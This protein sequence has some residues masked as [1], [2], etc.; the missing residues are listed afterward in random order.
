MLEAGRGFHDMQ[1]HETEIQRQCKFK[2]IRK[3]QFPR[4]RKVGRQEKCSILA[5]GR[6]HNELRG[7]ANG[8]Y[9]NTIEEVSNTASS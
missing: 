8:G 5:C 7:A 4:L 1:D 2:S 3:Y 9:E 6:I